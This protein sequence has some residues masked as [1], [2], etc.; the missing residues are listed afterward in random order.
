M[1]LNEDKKGE[2]GWGRGCSP[3]GEE[4]ETTKGIVGFQLA[5]S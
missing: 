2:G 1:D 4:M 5:L 3:L